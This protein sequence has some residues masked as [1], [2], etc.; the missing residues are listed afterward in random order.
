MLAVAVHFFK[1]FGMMMS[2]CDN[3]TN[4]YVTGQ[5]KVQGRVVQSRVKLTQD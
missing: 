2:L 3:M 1:A 4:V 5:N